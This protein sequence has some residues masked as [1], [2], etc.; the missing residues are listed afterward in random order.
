MIFIIFRTAI[1][2]SLVCCDDV[3]FLPFPYHCRSSPLQTNSI[4]TLKAFN[5]RFN[6]HFMFASQIQLYIQSSISILSPHRYF[7]LRFTNLNILFNINIQQIF[8]LSF[9]FVIHPLFFFALIANGW[10]N[11][12]AQNSQ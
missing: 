9:F 5:E 10:E 2:G 12:W 11:V 8:F 1:K 7:L 4:D 3:H 6:F